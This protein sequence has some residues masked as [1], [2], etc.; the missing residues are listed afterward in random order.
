MALICT[1]LALPDRPEHDFLSPTE[2][3]SL[4]SRIKSAGIAS[5]A[6]LFS[7]SEHELKEGLGLSDDEVHRLTYLLKRG[8]SIAF[9]IESL[10]K[11]GIWML[12]IMDEDYPERLKNIIGE[13]AP[14]VLFGAGDQTLLSYCGLAVAGAAY[15][16]SGSLSFVE[17]LSSQC[18]KEGISI[19]SETSR[20]DDSTAMNMFLGKGCAVVGVLADSLEKHISNRDVRGFILDSLLTVISPFHPRAVRSIANAARQKTL[21]YALAENAMVVTCRSKNDGTW[22]GASEAIRLS[23]CTVHVRDDSATTAGNRALMELG[24][25]PVSE[26]QLVDLK[27]ILA[28]Q[29]EN[30]PP[31]RNLTL[32]FDEPNISESSILPSPS[33]S[34]IQKS[35]INSEIFDSAAVLILNFLSLPRSR[36]EIEKRLELTTQQTKEWLKD[37]ETSGQITK[38][39]RPLLYQATDVEAASQREVAVAELFELVSIRF[40]EFLSE[41]RTEEQILDRFGILPIQAKAWLGRMMADGSVKKTLKPARYQSILDLFSSLK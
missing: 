32:S 12:T 29:K 14:P 13:T 19:V 40:R 35:K 4:N 15:M 9:E 7:M 16:D 23:L 33:P 20:N 25:I 26:D 2:W 31:K 18:A 27:Q 39:S 24:A 5:P 22:A 30:Q 8:G 3:H 28:G 17:A 36:E 6:G 34:P 21:A 38:T 11:R 41:P 10:E 37:L 1:S